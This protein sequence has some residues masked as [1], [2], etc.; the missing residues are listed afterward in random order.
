MYFRKSSELS[1][2]TALCKNKQKTRFVFFEF[3]LLPFKNF[4]F[5]LIG[6]KLLY[7]FVLVS[8]VQQCE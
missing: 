4:I 7:S 8:A 2:E 1:P 3:F 5:I 6:G